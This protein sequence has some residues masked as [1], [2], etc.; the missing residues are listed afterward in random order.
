[1][2]L[3]FSQADI[4]FQ[5][6]VRGWIE[7]NYPQEMRDRKKR[8]PGGSLRKEDHVYW[9]QALHTKGWSA[10][11]WPVEYGGPGFTPT[12]RYLFDLEMARADTPHIVPFGLG[13]VAPVIMKFGTQ[14]QKDKYLPDILASKV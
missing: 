12:Q 9:Q 2:D 1:M 3:T 8:S 6:E 7:A 13:M 5:M 11:G 4:D 14:E 10:P